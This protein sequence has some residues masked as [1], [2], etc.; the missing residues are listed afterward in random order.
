MLHWIVHGWV[1]R[2]E[3]HGRICGLHFRARGTKHW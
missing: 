3:H 1:N 2:Y